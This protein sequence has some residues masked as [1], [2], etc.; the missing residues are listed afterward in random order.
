MSQGRKRLSLKVRIFPFFAS[1]SEINSQ[2]ALKDEREKILDHPL[3]SRQNQGLL[4]VCPPPLIRISNLN[5]T[6]CNVLRSC[7]QWPLGADNGLH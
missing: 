5:I 3:E 1:I 2:Q 6:D 4:T 7:S